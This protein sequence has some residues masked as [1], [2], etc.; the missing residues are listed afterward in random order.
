M[1]TIVFDL[2]TTG[3]PI[4]DSGRGWGAPSFTSPI[5]YSSCRVVSIA[6]LEIPDPEASMITEPTLSSI[7]HMLIRP[8]GFF[9]PA[10]STAIHGIT[11]AEA[12][13]DGIPFTEMLAV[14]MRCVVNC[15]TIVSHN[16]DFDIN[17]L[18]HE[19]YCRGLMSEL[20]TVQSKKIVCTMKLSKSL[21]GLSRVPKLAAIYE[22]LYK[23]PIE[24][25]H[26][27]KYDTWY[28][29]KVYLSLMSTEKT[30]ATAT[31]PTKLDIT[32]SPEQE[33][34]VTAPIDNHLLV[35]AC[36]GSGKTTTILCRIWWLLRQ[37]VAP[38]TIILTTFTRA[39]A[40][41]M[42]KK[43]VAIIGYMPDIE[44]GTLD[45][46]FLKQL[47][48]SMQDGGHSV[49]EYGVL[50]RAYLQ[51][52]D[53]RARALAGKRF[54]FVD[55]YQDINAVQN[56]IIQVY[57]DS[58][59][60]V[61]AIGDDAQN[62]YGWRGSKMEYILDFEE[63]MTTKGARVS[64]FRLS[65]NYRSTPSIVALANASIE[66]NEYQYPKTMVAL[67]RKAKEILPD[68]RYYSSAVLQNE[69][70][71]N[72]ITRYME[73]GVKPCDMAVLCSQNSALYPLEEMLTRL[74]V[75]HIFA[76]KKSA[77]GGA[78]TASSGVF[79]G[80]IH[81]AKGLEWRVVFLVNVND[82]IFPNKRDAQAD[83]EES[84][85]VFYVAV[86]RAKHR[87]HISFVR[88]YSSRY[89]SRF[90]SE[91]PDHL[92]TFPDKSAEFFGTS[93][94]RHKFVKL[95]VTELIE[96]LDGERLAELRAA[97]LIPALKWKTNLLY[98]EHQ[99][100]EEVVASELQTD[101]GIFIDT[102]I[103]RML[104]RI[105]PGILAGTLFASV[106][107]T[108]EEMAVYNRFKYYFYFNTRSMT[109][110]MSEGAAMQMLLAP[111]PS[112][113][114]SV[115]ATETA[116]TDILHHIL[117][118]LRNMS[119]RCS[120]PID[121]VAVMTERFLP[122]GYEAGMRENWT[123]YR[124]T[125]LS[126]SETLLDTWE[127]S[128]CERIV[129]ERRRRLLFRRTSPSMIDAYR[130]LLTDLETIVQPWL[131]GR[132]EA[133]GAPVCHELYRL[134]NGVAG[135]IDI[136]WGT[137]IIDIKCS[138]TVQIG[139][140]WMLQLLTYAYMARIHG[141]PIDTIAVFNPLK[142]LWHEAS[143]AELSDDTLK[144]IVGAINLRSQ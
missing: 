140:D 90:V 44:V 113:I 25:A 144:T 136:R 69:N 131:C 28:C 111:L 1:T 118:L 51:D 89:V 59:V 125:R 142:G 94:T 33:A 82:E 135:E 81:K 112:S 30:I 37:G 17:V 9:V 26:N 115:A 129:K 76:E 46:L 3:L 133:Q 114:S 10:A 93:D 87:L 128:K 27:A 105:Y 88:W 19:L 65:T 78:A 60:Y 39:A 31:L 100:P 64:S 34:V 54:L 36:A 67:P 8:D 117:N 116:P 53:N 85:R 141:I 98:A 57:V 32:L 4:R 41:D 62:I 52:P 143:I 96:S 14:F 108:K 18:C 71:A 95:R 7:Q 23:E 20:Q 45:S 99:H 86:T 38:H 119:S 73:V 6:W 130:P 40:D 106:K 50:Y 48:N 55:E 104:G 103:C 35:I 11:H 127:V 15:T 122:S 138:H 13:A 12:T 42:R 72:M 139:P 124:D 109:R 120:I 70:V 43:L 47:G 132:F 77:G 68:V 49:S 137:T 21:L 56:D 24:N 107:L 22:T 134:P 110:D 92:Y 75:P 84:R 126:N 91:L 97:G 16:T 66:K 102:L 121:Q 29:Y 58:G 80:T 61:I 2:E 63:Q 83:I 5:A 101:I 123:R 74:Q 79:L